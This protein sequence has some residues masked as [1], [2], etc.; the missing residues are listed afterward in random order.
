M[1]YLPGHGVYEYPYTPE[2]FP[3]DMHHIGEAVDAVQDVMLSHGF[4]IHRPY[5]ED[6]GEHRTV[7]DYER[8][9]D[10]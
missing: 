3:W 7:H 1:T 4:D 10:R 8:A 5:V 6:D 2:S 9:G